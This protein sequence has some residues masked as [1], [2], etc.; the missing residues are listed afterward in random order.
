MK[1]PLSTKF[2]TGFFDL[3]MTDGEENESR[4]DRPHSKQDSGTEIGGTL[5][6][7]QFDYER[8]G[9][10]PEIE[11]DKEESRSEKT[12][13][14]PVITDENNEENQKLPLV[15]YDHLKNSPSDTGSS[16]QQSYETSPDLSEGGTA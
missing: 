4:K 15:V 6:G 2:K 1:R 16:L 14:R 10:V 3:K 8:A 9:S 11:E 5:D 12:T 7:R 13:P